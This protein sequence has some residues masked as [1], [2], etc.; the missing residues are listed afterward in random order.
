M[1]ILQEAGCFPGPVWMCAENLTPPGFDPRS[2]QPI[3]SRHT[4]YA[5]PAHEC[6]QIWSYIYM[7]FTFHARYCIR[8]VG[9][10]ERRERAD[11]QTEG[12]SW[13]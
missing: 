6:S 9:L 4:N 7:R 8:S 5:I 3:A 12:R 10:V 13:K 2:A 11:G 1:P